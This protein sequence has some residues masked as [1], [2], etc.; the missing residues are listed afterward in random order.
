MH[1][2]TRGHLQT[3]AD[4]RGR[5]VGRRNHGGNLDGTTHSV[6]SNC[7]G[8]P[9]LSLVCVHFVGEISSVAVW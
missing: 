2:L 4:V 6:C 7:V 9:K 3:H 1:V 8:V 5:L